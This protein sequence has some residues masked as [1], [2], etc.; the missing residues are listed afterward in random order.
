MGKCRML[1]C[2]KHCEYFYFQNLVGDQSL[3][4]H[5]A[6]K[7]R[8]EIKN[9]SFDTAVKFTVWIATFIL[10]PFSLRI[11]INISKWPNK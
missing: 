7:H 2:C 10:L 1:Y 8:E 5:V 4:N 3:N 9:K 11:K 6:K